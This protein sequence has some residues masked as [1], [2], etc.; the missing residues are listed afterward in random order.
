MGRGWK[1]ARS[2]PRQ[3]LTRQT[4]L[5]SLKREVRLHLLAVKSPDM[6][7]KELVLGVAAYN[8]T[9][10]AMNEAGSALGLN[11]REFSF[12][13]AQDTLNAYL[14]VFAK[15]TSDQERQR[16]A[17]EML[18]VFAQSKLPRRRKRSSYPRKIW[19]R[20]CSF[21]KRNV[22]NKRGAASQKKEVA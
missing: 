7:A 3:S 5:R 9:R 17:Q 12:S 10:A 1:R 8:L 15:A 19:P 21:P 14:P 16:I 18:R 20:P 22:A 6:A 2:A 13:Q 11:P 4:D